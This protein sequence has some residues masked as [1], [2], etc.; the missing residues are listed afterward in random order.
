M[1]RNES[2]E[3]IMLLDEVLKIIF[4]K[5]LIFVLVANCIL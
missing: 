2:D 5:C 1:G 4:K 3:D